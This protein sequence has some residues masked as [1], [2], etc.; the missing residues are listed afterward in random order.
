MNRIKVP[1]AGVV[2]EQKFGSVAAVNFV[3]G[4]CAILCVQLFVYI[5]NVMPHGVH[6]DRKFICNFFIQ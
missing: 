4:F 3:E 2:M 1:Y 5:M 6:G